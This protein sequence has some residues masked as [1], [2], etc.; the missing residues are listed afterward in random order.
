MREAFRGKGV[1]KALVRR[2]E[3]MLAEKGVCTII[4]A[5]GEENVGAR[6]FYERCGYGAEAEVL[7]SKEVGV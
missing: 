5:T 6:R 2:L 7:Y 3:G 4:V 1:A